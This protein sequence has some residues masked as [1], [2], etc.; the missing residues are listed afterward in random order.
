MIDFNTAYND[1]IKQIEEAPAIR[2][3]LLLKDLNAP[4]IMYGLGEQASLLLSFCNYY[5]VSITGFA[6]SK[7]RG[8]FADTQSIIMSPEELVINYPDAM[9]LISSWKYNNAIFET[10][11]SF[12][13]RKEQIYQFPFSHPYFLLRESFETNHLEGY[14]R[15]YEFFDDDLSKQIICDRISAYLFD[16]TLYKTSTKPK[17]F[18][19]LFSEQEVFVQAGT[20]CGET[21]KEF[22]DIC[23][24][25]QQ[26]EV[27]TFEADPQA[28]EISKKTLS[29][30]K[31][32][33]LVNKGLWST[34][35]TLIF[36]TDALSGS[37]SF[38]N[39]HDHEIKMPVTSLDAFFLD[40]PTLPTFIQL[41]I[42]GAE[43]E[44]LKGA[45]QIIRNQKPKLAICVYHKYEDVYEIPELLY[46]FNP[47]YKFWLQHCEDGIY[48]TI[49]YAM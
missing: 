7:K 22:L 31:N 6:D 21:V 49:L 2:N 12:G 10:L 35:S 17:Y 48:D 44:A 15:A 47:E 14:K 1:I 5:S 40:K 25:E 39:G 23:S 33:Y 41:D 36:F 43:L 29:G 9:I 24:S 42:E 28:Y 11:K 45:E 18:E 19:F 30:F 8:E 3:L 34:E 20:Y 37:A 13:Y 26:Y 4:I 32:I 46:Q 38:V 27:Y 16:K